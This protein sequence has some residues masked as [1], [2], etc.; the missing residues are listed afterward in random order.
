M[1]FNTLFYTSLLLAD[2]TELPVWV[3]KSFPV[4]EII[5]VILLAICSIFMIVAV[6]LQKSDS[7]GVA[8]ITGRSAD[9]FYNRNKSGS[10]QGKVKKLIMIDAIVILVLAV[11][12]MICYSIC[13]II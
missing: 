4:L 1:N 8:G 7:N 3:T 11:L 5:F 13:P 10:L 6:I 12:F 9:T 2:N